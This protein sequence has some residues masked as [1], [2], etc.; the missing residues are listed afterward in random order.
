M[1]E[2]MSAEADSLARTS[3]GPT[4]LQTIGRCYIS[5][6]CCCRAKYLRELPLP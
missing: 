2:A 1:Q 5:Q 3:C 6:V 4:I